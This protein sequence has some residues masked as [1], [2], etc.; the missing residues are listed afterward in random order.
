MDVQTLRA[1]LHALKV[2]SPALV[3]DPETVCPADG[4]IVLVIITSYPGWVPSLVVLV[5]RQP[6]AKRNRSMYRSSGWPVSMACFM[7]SVF[8][9]GPSGQRPATLKVAGLACW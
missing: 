1:E 4:A 6:S 8:R 9:D 7:G 5:T 2:A 3:A